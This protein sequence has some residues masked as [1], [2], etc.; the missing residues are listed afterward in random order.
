MI[1]DFLFFLKTLFLSTVVV[2]LLQV[3]IQNQTL[4]VL[5]YDLITKSSYGQS[6]TSTAQ[7]LSDKM[8]RSVKQ[9]MASVGRSLSEPHKNG[10]IE[11]AGQRH[12]NFTLKRS[13]S[14]L[15]KLRQEEEQKSQAAE[16][17]LD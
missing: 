9:L 12:L 3:R 11:E 6:L 2:L 16:D 10:F 5:A 15:Q 7:F 4:E 1:S 17:D 8:Q 14:Y 13:E